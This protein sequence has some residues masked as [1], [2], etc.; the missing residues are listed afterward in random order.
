MEYFPP[1]CVI[2][3]IYIKATSKAT[4]DF[5]TEVAIFLNL[6]GKDA[7]KLLNTFNFTE[8]EI[9]S[10]DNVT[11]AFE[12]YCNPKKNVDYERFMF[13]K[14]CQQESE[15]FQKFLPYLKKI[16]QIC[17]Y[18]TLNDEMVRDRIVLG[19]AD[20]SLRERL[21][22]IEDLKLQEA[23]DTCKAAEISKAQEKNLQDK[24]VA[25]VS[26]KSPGGENLGVTDVRKYMVFVNV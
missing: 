9:K 19:A 10:I 8:D 22:R 11:T 5:E 7:L 4:K 12:N 2:Y 21:L 25:G 26:K 1:R 14:R 3:K 20:L 16:S 18:G 15:P 13:N 23:V 24:I 6:A 17:E